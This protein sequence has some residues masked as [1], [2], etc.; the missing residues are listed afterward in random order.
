MF[1]A[2]VG[3]AVDS[4]EQGHFIVPHTVRVA[5]RWIN[6]EG[7]ENRSLSE[8]RAALR[9]EDRYEPKTSKRFSEWYLCALALSE[10]IQKWLH[11]EKRSMKED[12]YPEDI[13]AIPIKQISLAEQKPFVRLEKERHGLWRELVA[14]EAEGFRIGARIEM[15]IR[16]LV[17]RFL[18]EHPKVEHLALLKLPSSLVEFEESA[19]ESDLHGARA[20]GAEV[21]LRRVTIARVGNGVERKE[22]IAALLARI[23]AS[24]PAP[25][26]EVSVE[27]PRRERDLLALAAFLG[28]Q[29]EGI[30]RRQARIEA[31]QQE[32]DRLAW[33]L[34]RPAA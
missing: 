10:P 15:P 16:D 27:I 6:L 32:I 7:V 31:I 24:L 26:S 14:L 8:A 12:V 13:K 1:G 25:L 30:R 9:D 28:E 18:R 17:E 5:V 21:R 3:V 33:A 4:G 22:E 23:L 2:F 11:A 19:L 34:Y 29:E 20:A